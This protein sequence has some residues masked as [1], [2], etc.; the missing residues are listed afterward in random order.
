MRDGF[1]WGDVT[2]IA[3]DIL[4]FSGFIKIN[5]LS[6]TAISAA[7]I[8]SNFNMSFWDS[9]ISAAMLENNIFHIYTENTKD[10]KVPGIIA[11]NPF[12]K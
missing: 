4:N 7:E 11:V 8:A 5:Y 3:K 6:K 12:A 9:L 10:F 2:E 1:L